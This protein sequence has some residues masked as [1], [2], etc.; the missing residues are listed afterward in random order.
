MQKPEVEFS[1]FYNRCQVI[2][3]IFASSFVIDSNSTKQLL[4]NNA[5]IGYKAHLSSYYGRMYSL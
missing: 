1:Q 3:S 5:I 2:F 4:E